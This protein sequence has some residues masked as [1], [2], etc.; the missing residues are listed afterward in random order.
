MLFT[1]VY[2]EYLILLKCKGISIS[3]C[4]QLSVVVFCVFVTA[5]CLMDMMREYVSNAE[6]P[7]IEKLRELFG[8]VTDEQKLDILL[9][10]KTGLDMTA[11][12]GAACR[13]DAEMITTILSTLQSS[14]RLKRLMMTDYWMFT[15]LHT[16]ASRGN[17]ESVKAILNSLQSSDRLKLL[18]MRA[19][20]QHTPLHIAAS[21]G[22]TESVK[23]LLNSLTA[24][25]QMQLLIVE[26]KYGKTAVEMASGETADV[27]SE[28][29]NRAREKADPGEF[30]PLNSHVM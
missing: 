6:Y 25:Q 9:Q 30:I 3:L 29:K 12:H 8:E 10:T 27:L 4:V 13:D 16:A 2:N 7:D 23:A 20:R 21:E 5:L 19:F 24:D 18:M 11:L 28:Y 14:D 1:A 26:D 15:P 22:H 17:T